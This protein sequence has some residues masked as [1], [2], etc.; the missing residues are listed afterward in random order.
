M[1]LFSWC[2]PAEANHSACKVEFKRWWYEKRGKKETIVYGDMIECSCK[3]HGKKKT[4]PKAR[5]RKS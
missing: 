5:K 2:M 4:K 1:A 3:C